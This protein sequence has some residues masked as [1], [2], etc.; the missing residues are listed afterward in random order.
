MYIII[1]ITS[2]STRTIP[3]SHITALP[4]CVTNVSFIYHYYRFYTHT[5]TCRAGWPDDMMILSVCSSSCLTGQC[6]CCCGT[7]VWATNMP[8]W[9]FGSAPSPAMP[10]K[11][12]SWWWELTMTRYSPQSEARSV[13]LKYSSSPKPRFWSW[14]ITTTR[15]IQ[16]EARS[17]RHKALVLVVGNHYHKVQ[18]QSEA[19]SIRPKCSSSSSPGS[20]CGKSLPQ[21]AVLQSEAYSI[22]PK[23]SSSSSPGSGSGKS[24]PQGAVLQ[25]EA[26][27]IR[28]K[29]SSSS[30]PGSGSGKSLP[31]GA[32]L[33]FE[34][35]LKHIQHKA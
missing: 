22:R 19:Y 30:S 29:C 3:L 35:Y 13:R 1:I 8:V 20:G 12:R 27:S 14:E 34:A 5:R 21:G 7:S 32:V 9:T 23:C 6:T 15:C 18:L 2:K 31:Q 16:S 24:L 17:I 28:P 33:H 11:P 25:S 10:P 26:Y 4:L